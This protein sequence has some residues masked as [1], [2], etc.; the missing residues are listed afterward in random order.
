MYFVA[1]FLCREE[2]GG[3]NFVQNGPEPIRAL[4]PV[5]TAA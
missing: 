3:A 5:R 1:G 2:Y 4:V